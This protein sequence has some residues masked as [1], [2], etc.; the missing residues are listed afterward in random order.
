MCKWLAFQRWGGELELGWCVHVCSN[1][2]RAAKG[3]IPV[4]RK[5]GTL[6]SDGWLQRKSFCFWFQPSAGWQYPNNN[7]KVTAI[8]PSEKLIGT[9]CFKHEVTQQN[10]CLQMSGKLESSPQLRVI[11]VIYQTC[12]GHTRR[13]GQKGVWFTGWWLT[14]GRASCPGCLICSPDSGCLEQSTFGMGSPHCGCGSAPPA[15]IEWLLTTGNFK[16]PPPFPI[17]VH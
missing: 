16:P 15:L 17:L 3:W 6:H 11:N 9:R 5:T 7:N 10:I 14:V 13:N 8:F 2:Q 4:K 12:S 1:V